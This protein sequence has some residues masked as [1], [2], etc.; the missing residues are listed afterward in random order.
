[1]RNRMLLIL[2]LLASISTTDD[3][4]S[5]DSSII[6]YYNR[7]IGLVNRKIF[8][9]NFKSRD[10]VHT[11]TLPYYSNSDYGSGVWDP[12]WSKPNKTVMNLAKEAGVSVVRYAVGNHWDWK[13][14]IGKK[15]K[16]FLFGLDEFLKTTEEI[17]ADAVII[18]SPT[19]GSELDAAEL[20]EY[21]NA[22]CDGTNINGGTDWA[23]E[24]A[25]NGHPDPYRVKYFEIGNETYGKGSKIGKPDLYVR[26]YLKYYD[27]MKAVDPS[28]KI[29][30]VLPPTLWHSWF[31]RGKV[32]QAIK[33]NID[34]G[35][36]HRYINSIWS[37]GA[38]KTV[39]SGDRLK[40]ALS[41]PLLTIDVEI[42][43]Y[44]QR[45]KESS[46][47]DIQLAISEYNSW[48][49]N[50]EHR[51][52]GAALVNAE[53]LKIFM[54]P[55]NN[56]LMANYWQMSNGL[57]GMVKA[58]KSYQNNPNSIPIHYIKRPSYYVFELY[59]QHFGD[60]L[61]ESDV[62]SDSYD[63]SNYPFYNELIK[64]YSLDKYSPSPNT[65]IPYLSVNT[66][67]SVDGTKVYV[68]VLNKNMDNAITSAVELKNMLPEKKLRAWILNGPTVS[69]D[70]EKYDKVKITHKR[71]KIENNLFTFTFEAHSLTAI[72]IATRKE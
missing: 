35:I 64:A 10:P 16:H 72:E 6:V 67:K 50:D 65:R 2:V 52:L 28:V 26:I 57:Y 53:L 15:R 43:E 63:L 34:Y 47:K 54:K 56:I 19:V 49:K 45:L 1:M 18:V 24:R 8:G 13:S 9:N 7:D 33:E 70:N 38:V 44:L 61:I 60:V 46:A 3:A 14:A 37:E 12:K 31:Q 29:G 55:E 32:L 40:V 36:L 58:D 71:S 59:N 62:H 27:A 66:S 51:R 21:L 17:G 41:M 48:H 39:S 20:I 4:Y 5:G 68:M 42:P 25:R 23:E 30:F 11:G 69:S 22:P